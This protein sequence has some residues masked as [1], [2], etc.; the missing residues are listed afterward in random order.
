MDL[1]GQP[2]PLD[3]DN[4]L[5]ADSGATEADE[6]ELFLQSVKQLKQLTSYNILSLPPRQLTSLSNILSKLETWGVDI[7]AEDGALPASESD[8][9]EESQ[10]VRSLLDTREAADS[11]A[12]NFKW[13]QNPEAPQQKACLRCLQHRLCE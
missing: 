1:S 4:H 8:Y 3:R 9:K 11:I 10:A 13:L 5:T 6:Q 2:P 7:D 12:K